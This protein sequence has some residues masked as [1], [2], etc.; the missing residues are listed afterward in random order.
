MSKISKKLVLILLTIVMAF[1]AFMIAP[2]EANASSEI[3]DKSVYFAK[4][5]FDSKNQPFVAIFVY[6]PAS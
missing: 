6:K 5:G 4:S 1:S 2:F 3:N